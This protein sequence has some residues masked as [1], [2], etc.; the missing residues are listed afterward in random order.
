[1]HTPPLTR[2]LLVEDEMDIQLV[3]RLALERFG[4]Y[5]LAI[6]SSG[7][8]ALALAQ[9]FQPQLIL[10]DVMMP[11]LDG[12][13]T[14]AALREIPALVATPVIFVTARAQ[15]HEVAEYQE[16]GALDVILK[17]FD[18]IGLSDQIG[19]AWERH[20]RRAPATA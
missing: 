20:W 19:A 10:L 6:A 16:L 17:P 9:S 14:L 2:V 3:A 8:E 13:G 7:E 11:G 4:S 18:P 5:E 12:F 1:M 15:N